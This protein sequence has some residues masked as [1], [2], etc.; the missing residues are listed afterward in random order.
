MQRHAASAV[1]A[2]LLVAIGCS[3]SAAQTT[4][5]A[6]TSACPKG[7]LATVYGGT[8]KCLGLAVRKRIYA[9]LTRT[10]DRAIAGAAAYRAVSARYEISVD[11]A[12]RID[13]EGRARGWF[14]PPAPRLAAGVPVLQPG[15]DGAA[16]HLRVTGVECRQSDGGLAVADLR[17]TP[18]VDRGDEQRVAVTIY[19]G[20]FERGQFESSAPLSPDRAAMTWPRVHGRAFH[21]VRILTLHE[22]G[23]HPSATVKFEGVACIYDQRP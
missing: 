19:P 20:G 22:D 23:W 12:R 4:G 17:W 6:P 9:A 11:S 16:M 3:S 18:A 13:R 7:S 21:F 14:V 10:R 1:A 15:G 8:H 5:S 2:G